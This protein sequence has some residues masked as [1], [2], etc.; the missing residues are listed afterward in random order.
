MR[1]NRLQLLTTLL[2]ITLLASCTD[3]KEEFTSAPLSDYVPL[4][5]GKYLTYRL[6]STVFSDFGASIEWHSY[7]EK[8]L[9]DEEI[10]D[11]I[12]RKGFRILRYLRNVA[13]TQPWA[14]AG[15]Y[16]IIPTGGTVEFIENNLRFIKLALPVKQDFQWKGNQYLP[17]N[18]LSNLFTF[19]NDNQM[20]DWTYRFDTINT[21]VSLNNKIFN[22][23]ITVIGTNEVKVADT[24]QV[25]GT[26]AQISSSMQTVYLR[27]NATGT[28]I[29]TAQPPKEAGKLNVY[30]RTNYPAKLD[31]MIIPVNGGKSFE[32]VNNK[33]TFGFVNDRG[34][35]TDTLYLDLP[36]GSKDVLIEKF[37]KNIGMIQ[38]EF[39]MWEYQ[40]IPNSTNGGYTN[41]FGLRRTLID[42]N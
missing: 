2:A 16:F 34:V 15:T 26:A 38:Q 20:S 39:T 36:Y 21:T 8:H 42:H 30:N 41:G 33:W 23:V 35:R 1:S 37:A 29:L 24:I 4:Q 28:I 3:E 13:G 11:G 40:Y 17:D 19:N 18:P 14:P 9:V 10:T 7:Q 31:T 22:D 32:Y 6:D 12:G 27:G 25:S 5:K